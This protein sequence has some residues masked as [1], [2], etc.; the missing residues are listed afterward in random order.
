MR[1]F[2]S[3]AIF[4]MNR[5]SFPKK[6]TFIGMLFALPLAV[7]LYLLIAEIK[8]EIDF[9]KKEV[10]GNAYLR[11]LRTLLEDLQLRRGMAYAA[12]GGERVSNPDAL[13]ALRGRVDTDMQAVAEADRL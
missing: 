4:A 13:L 9:A 2:F 6:F 1:S 3:P 5:L 12:Y 11:P 10:A 8:H 7:V